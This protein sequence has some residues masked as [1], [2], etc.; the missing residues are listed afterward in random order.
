[1]SL[2]LKKIAF[3][4]AFSALM[5]CLSF[6]A[7]QDECSIWLCLPGG[8][9]SGCSAAHAA[10]LKRL[11]NLES[12]L[13]SFSSCA[14]EADNTS[15]NYSVAAY[16]PEHQECTKYKSKYN[17][18]GE[19]S[20]TCVAYKTVAAQYIKGKRCTISKNKNTDTITR[21]PAYCSSTV[22]YIDIYQNGSQLGDTYY[23]TY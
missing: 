14:T 2:N 6:A 13:P 1:M 18:E 9:P 4:A 3:V 8:F 22:R 21:S 23:F 17:R 5:P 19:Y 7:S 16:I 12:P 11:K 15:Y 20:Q 10:M